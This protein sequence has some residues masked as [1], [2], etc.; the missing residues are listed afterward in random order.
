[1]HGDRRD[2]AP[3]QSAFHRW[4]CIN[5]R[6]HERQYTTALR[7]FFAFPLFFIPLPTAVEITGELVKWVPEGA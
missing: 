2:P 4:T 1:V 6:F 3:R 7:V 5:L